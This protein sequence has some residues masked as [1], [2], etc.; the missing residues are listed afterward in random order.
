M[1]RVT[2]VSARLGSSSPGAQQEREASHDA[3]PAGGDIGEP[4]VHR[5]APH[6]RGGPDEGLE[7]LG[8][9]RTRIEGLRALGHHRHDHVAGA[10]HRLGEGAV[11]GP[12]RV[13]EDR[14]GHD[15]RGGGPEGVERLGVE[16]A[17]PGRERA[18]APEQRLVALLVDAHDHGGAGGLRGAHG[19][20]Q[21]AHPRA[22]GREKA[23]ER[24]GRE[25]E[26]DAERGRSAGEQARASRAA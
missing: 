13:E 14:E 1:K 2:I 23:P 8:D 9:A 11:L 15:P 22:G 17:G 19:E 6:G 26:G 4:L 12:L 10:A 3:V 5:R 25:H 7:L 21:V 20:E 24:G 16:R 18:V